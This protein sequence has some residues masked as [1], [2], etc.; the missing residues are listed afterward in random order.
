MKKMPIHDMK[1]WVHDLDM[2]IFMLE[3][4]W[5]KQLASF[6]CSTNQISDEL[7]PMLINKGFIVSTMKDKTLHDLVVY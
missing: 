5:K 2:V 3:D 6:V 4:P 7:A 1:V